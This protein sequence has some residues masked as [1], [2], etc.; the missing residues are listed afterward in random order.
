L[1]LHEGEYVIS[2][3]MSFTRMGMADDVKEVW[4][5]ERARVLQA[6]RARAGQ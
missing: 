3:C 4:W 6:G 1:F 2:A 5:A